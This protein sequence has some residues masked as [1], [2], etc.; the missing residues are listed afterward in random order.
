MYLISGE[1]KWTFYPP[2]STSHLQ[3]VLYDSLDP[4]FKS[5]PDEPLDVPSYTVN[6]QPGQLLFVPAGSPHKVKQRKRNLRVKKNKKMDKKLSLFIRS[7]HESSFKM[8]F[9]A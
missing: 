5:G 7:Q 2:E 6:L 8:L 9:L 1:K 3:P 4:V